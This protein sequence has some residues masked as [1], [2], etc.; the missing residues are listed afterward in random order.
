MRNL[1]DKI[2]DLQEKLTTGHEFTVNEMLGFLAYEKQILNLCKGYDK[3][4]SKGLFKKSL[5]KMAEKNI[6]ILKESYYS[7]G[8]IKLDSER[9]ILLKRNNKKIRNLFA[10]LLNFLG[11][12]EARKEYEDIR[13]EDEN[14]IRGYENVTGVSVMYQKTLQVLQGEEARR[15]KYLASKRE[16]E[17]KLLIQTLRKIYNDYESDNF[18]LIQKVGDSGLFIKK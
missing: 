9:K 1:S 15:K 6:E 10:G 8:G 4:F 2:R 17:S 12:L 7:L 16:F 14:M 3:R 18:S 11:L 5:T 13:R